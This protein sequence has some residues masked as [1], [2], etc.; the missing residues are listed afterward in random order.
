MTR[1]KKIAI[2]GGIGS[3]KSL[4]CEILK[5]KGYSVFSCDSISKQLRKDE[6]YL[7]LVKDAFPECVINGSLS[8]SALS[9]RVF[10][11]EAARKK[12]ESISHPLI[13]QRLFAEMEKR[14]ISFAEVPLLFEGGFE[15][16]F[17]AV[18][19]LVRPKEARIESVI[20]RSA[21]TREQVILRMQ[22]QFDYNRIAEKNCFV[23]ENNGTYENLKE[24][25]DEILSELCL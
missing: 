16:S 6:E 10:S 22:S 25:A 23:I 3:G 14:P 5:E 17:D 13:M 18:I 11:D 20:A 9:E 8:E 7:A 4:F 24:K 12:L 1:N 2:T 21:L 15:S 19:A